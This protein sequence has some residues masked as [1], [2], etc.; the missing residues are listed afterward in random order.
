MP[1]PPIGGRIPIAQAKGAMRLSLMEM[2]AA[3]LSGAN[4]ARKK[5]P[6]PR[7]NE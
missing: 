4:L 2:L 3:G 1:T 5:N 6:E 7:V